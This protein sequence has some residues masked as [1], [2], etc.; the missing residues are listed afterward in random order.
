MNNG[1]ILFSSYPKSCVKH[2]LD[3]LGWENHT[4]GDYRHGL[5]DYFLDKV[6]LGRL[7]RIFDQRRLYAAQNVQ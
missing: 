2:T 5:R 3:T 6:I 1:V 7:I 4:L